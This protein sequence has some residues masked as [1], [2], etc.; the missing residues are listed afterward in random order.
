[1]AEVYLTQ[2]GYNEK[3]RRLEKAI[4]SVKNKMGKNS[5]LRGMSY[6]EG[7]TARVRNTLIGGH[8]GN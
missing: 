2:E 7:A 5:I 3:E 1:M 4:S 6:Q 8:N